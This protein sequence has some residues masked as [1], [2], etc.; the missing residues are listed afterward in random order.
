MN[1]DEI[2][3]LHERARDSVARGEAMLLEQAA[4]HVDSLLKLAS[5]LPFEGRAAIATRLRQAAEQLEI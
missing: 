5:T 1:R 4:N 2:E 3:R